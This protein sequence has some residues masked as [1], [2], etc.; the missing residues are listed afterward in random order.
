MTDKTDPSDFLV[1]FDLDID[2]DTV[3]GRQKKMLKWDDWQ[4]LSNRKKR[5]VPDDP[6]KKC[7]ICNKLY[8]P[9]FY[10]KHLVTATHMKKEK[11]YFKLQLND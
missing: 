4:Q 11:E 6:R 2:R 5:Q 8:C 1:Y 10:R 9:D 7:L 3:E